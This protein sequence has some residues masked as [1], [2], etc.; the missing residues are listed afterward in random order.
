MKTTR[1]SQAHQDGIHWVVT[2]ADAEIPGLVYGAVGSNNGN[3][4]DL[5]S[6]ERKFNALHDF[7]AKARRKYLARVLATLCAMPRDFVVVLSAM[8]GHK[9]LADR[10]DLWPETAPIAKLTLTGRRTPG[11]EVSLKGDARKTYVEAVKR[12]AELLLQGASECFV[13]VFKAQKVQ[14]EQSPESLADK[15]IAAWK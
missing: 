6:L 5:Y 4:P 14:R 12:E 3:A 11:G 9:R 7:D 13:A 2:R 8:Y 1:L 10:F 15:V